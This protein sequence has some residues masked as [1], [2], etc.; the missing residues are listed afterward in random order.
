MSPAE[1][2]DT[3]GYQKKKRANDQPIGIQL[4]KKE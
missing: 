2:W 3:Q 4:T 1:G